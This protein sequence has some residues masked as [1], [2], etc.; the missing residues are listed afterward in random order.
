MNLVPAALCA[1]LVG[2]SVRA[3]Q[4][5]FGQ[6]ARGEVQDWRKHPIKVELMRGVG[7][8]G[9]I[10]YGARQ[11]SLWPTL[12]QLLK[13]HFALVEAPPVVQHL[14]EHRAIERDWYLRKLGH[15]LALKPRS[16]ELVAAVRALA[17][18]DNL[19][20]WRGRPIKL[21]ERT[22]QRRLKLYRDKGV[23][24]FAPKPRAD[25]GK[26]KVIIS[27]LCDW[28][29]NHDHEKLLT[30]RKVICDLVAQHRKSSL[31]RV[32]LL[33]NLRLRDELAAAGVPT[34]QLTDAVCTVPRRLISRVRRKFNVL[35]LFEN[36]HK[37]FQDIKPR[38]RRDPTT[39]RAM[40]LVCID[41]TPFD[42]VMLRPDGSRAHA[43]GICALDVG[44]ARLFFH[45]VL[46]EK[47]TAI[48]NAD[49]IDFLV[50]MATDPAWG[51]PEEIYI[52]NGKENLCFERL[53]E[54]LQLVSQARGTDGRDVLIHRSR[55]RNAPAKPVESYFA[56]FNK[57]LQ[58]LLGYTGGNRMSSHS[59][60]LDRPA[61]PF[62]GGIDFFRSIL[63]GRL[64]EWEIHILRGAF[65]GHRPREIYQG[66]LDRGWRPIMID[67]QNLATVFAKDK[68]IKFKQ[69]TLN[70]NGQL[71]RCKELPLECWQRQVIVRIPLY[72]TNVN[73]LAVLHPDTREVIGVA[74][75]EPLY[76]YGDPAGPE[77]ARDLNTSAIRQI[78][79]LQ[80]TVPAL[81]T[82]AYGQQVAAAIPRA[83]VATPE[84]LVSI[85]T[86]VARALSEPP[87]ERDAR[88]K[89]AKATRIRKATAIYGAQLRNRGFLK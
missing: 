4:R 44:T 6:I 19:D 64:L 15:L 73:E 35:N 72:R 46:C 3:T 84:G 9:G 61:F 51:L 76:E 79:T 70:W 77:A 52:D 38:V 85:G 36:R 2:G 57:F 59:E 89:Q 47:G 7:G 18:Q 50:L 65:K 27:L 86:D 74:R 42:I 17:A 68:L 81:D 22:I 53:E 87:A 39:L 40:Q 28:V 54:V 23:A 26:P 13:D 5:R 30:I 82:M 49:M 56:A 63:N 71:W 60:S 12:Q 25:K 78:R 24:A 58:D 14:G 88:N 31:V 10:N 34:E 21:T 69:G 11:D 37:D 33:A 43:R 20:D 83:P 41:V 48:R 55:P 75:P 80:K 8:A 62:D 29:L 66:N 1:E 45:Y 67:P 16:L 32:T